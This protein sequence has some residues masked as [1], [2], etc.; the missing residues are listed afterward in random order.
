MRN[1]ALGVHFIT[2][3]LQRKNAAYAEMRGVLKLLIN[4]DVTIKMIECKFMCKKHLYVAKKKCFFVFY[5]RRRGSERLFLCGNRIVI[6][7]LMR[8]GVQQN[9]N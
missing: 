6:M 5:Y 1:Y 3:T 7:L 4:L 8:L 2:V 9:I